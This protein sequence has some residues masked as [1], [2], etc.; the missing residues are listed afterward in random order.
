MIPVKRSL[1][2]IVLLLSTLNVFSSEWRVDAPVPYSVAHRGCHIDGLIPENCPAGVVYA[3]RYGFRAIECD[4]HYTK[5]SVLVLMHDATI[6]RTMR[7][8]NGYLPI[9]EPVHYADLTYQELCEHY[10]LSSSDP[11]LR[12]SIPT[13]EEELLECRRQGIL[14]MLHTD[15]FEA[16]AMAQRILGDNY[17]AFDGNYAAVSQARSLGNCL[18][19]WDPGIRTPEEIIPMLQAIGGPCGVSSMRRDLLTRDFIHALTSQGFHVQS[20]IF[21]TPHEMQAIHDGATII[22]SDFCLLPYARHG[23]STARV[24][25]KDL[26][27]NTGDTLLW[28]MPSAEHSSL[29]LQ[30]QFAGS[31]EII[32][33]ERR[34]Y[35]ITSSAEETWINGWRHQ[36]AEQPTL[37]LRATAP[38]TIRRLRLQGRRY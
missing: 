31:L 33:D 25:K 19:L 26:F 20:S 30:I 6:N 38:T 37:L 11:A 18:I 21:P 32:V 17:I 7:L 22:L 3:R 14:P 15:V 34:K 23:H 4:A 27:M 35:E 9:P 10:V 2:I 1:I 24:Q 5:D 12:T 13:L 36:G 8:R 16:Y 28:T 29:H